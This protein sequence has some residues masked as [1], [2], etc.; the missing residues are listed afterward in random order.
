MP[1]ETQIQDGASVPFFEGQVVTPAILNGFVNN[2]ILKRGAIS[3]QPEYSTTSTGTY[4]YATGNTL[5]IQSALHG[6]L[7]GDR[8]KA[9]FTN[10][11]GASGVDFNGYYEVS[12]INAN[13]FNITVVG[14]E[15]ASGGDVDYNKIPSAL[16]EILINDVADQDTVTPKKVTIDDLLNSRTDISVVTAEV[17]VLAGKNGKDLIVAPSD[18]TLITGATY[19]ST[20]GFTVTVTKA[21]H[22]LVAQENVVVVE[23]TDSSNPTKGEN[24]SGVFF[25]EAV[26]SNTFTYVLKKEQFITNNEFQEDE[27]DVPIVSTGTATYRRIGSVNNVGSSVFQGEVFANGITN[28]RDDLYVYGRARFGEFVLPKGRAAARPATPEEG[29]LFYNKD[30]DLIEIWRRSE[31]F[32]LGSWETFD[33]VS[34]TII[35]PAQ[36]SLFTIVAETANTWYSKTYWTLPTPIPYLQYEI[37]LPNIRLRHDNIDNNG[38]VLGKLELIAKSYTDPLEPESVIAGYY[39]EASTGSPFGVDND[40]SATIAPWTKII[41]PDDIDMSDKML[42]LRVSVKTTSVTVGSPNNESVRMLPFSGY[43]KITPLKRKGGTHIATPWKSKSQNDSL[44]EILPLEREVVRFWND[45]AAPFPTGAVC[46]ISLIDLN[47]SNGSNNQ[48]PISGF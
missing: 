18:G 28:L 31:A 46:P 43:V 25:V 2:A 23:C 6:L 17:G 30:D 26:T 24:Y 16:D 27:V 19:A 38:T 22:N 44:S 34:S 8:I 40:R 33:K 36:Y 21:N 12:I 47:F 45:A 20:D 32:P 3:S 15:L 42:T 11:T 1:I 39:S 9:E 10:L 4:T 5:L 7:T 37:E 41:T 29:Q 13:S 35:I 14:N 48:R